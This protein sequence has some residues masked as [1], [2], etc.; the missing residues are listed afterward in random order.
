MHDLPFDNSYARLGPHFYSRQL[1]EPVP[2]PGLIRVNRPLARHLGID[3]DW[4]ES[5]TG[6]GF[7]AGNHVPA[8]ADP[9]ATVY[10]GHQFGNWVPQLGDGRAILIGELV[11]AD[12]ER[13]DIQLKGSGRTPYSRGGDGRAPL[14]PVLREYIVSE[15]MAALGVPTTRALGAVTTG[16]TVFRETRLPGAVLTR[17]ARSHIRIGTF[18]Y[19][20]AQGD[21]EALDVLAQHVIERHYPEA[22]QVEQ[23]VVAMLEGVLERQAELIARW[24]SLGFI[25]GVMNTDNMLLSGETIDY[26]PCAF[27]DGFD[28]D[29]VFSSIDHGGRYAY[30]NQAH[31][32]HWNLARLAQAL[33]PLIDDDHD[34]AIEKGQAVI[35]TFPGQVQSAYRSAMLRKLGLGAARPGDGEL[36]RNLLELMQASHSDFTLAFRRLWELAAGDEREGDSIAAVFDFDKAFEPWLRS[37]RQRFADDP[38]DATTRLAAMQVANPAFI[39][40]NHLVEKT[41]AA[42]V[43]GPDFE[44]F[45]A[46]VGALENPFVFHIPLTHLATPPKP[47][48]EVTQT[49]C[50]T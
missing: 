3:P 19:F 9:V 21:R 33:L 39:P 41:I 16:E 22:A 5:E 35:N 45:H 11:A 50:G 32:A 47:G 12:G 36:I 29:A 28:N 18:E 38:A 30:R 40:R 42:A 46:L 34:R 23:P 24:Q 31:I 14:G 37:W 1:P 7:M 8:N 43:T 15:A 4:L 17:V 13:Y 48:Q 44:P 26:G 2:E 6:V 49:F 10:G 25:H 27:M 20:A